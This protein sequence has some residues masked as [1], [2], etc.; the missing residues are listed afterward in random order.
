MKK[1][2]IFT[3]FCMLPSCISGQFTTNTPSVTPEYCNGDGKVTIGIT[4]V[5]LGSTFDYLLQRLSG[6]GIFNDRNGSLG[7]I[8]QTALTVTQSNLP[9]RNSTIRIRENINGNLTTK[10]VSFTIAN[11]YT[12]LQFNN[13]FSYACFGNITVNVTQ[14]IPVTYELK[15]NTNG[16]VVVSAQSSNSFTGLAE[17]N[18]NVALTDQ[19]GNTKV[20][21]ATI[22]DTNT[23]LYFNFSSQD[24]NGFNYLYD[25]SHILHKSDLRRLV[26]TVTVP[27]YKYP[28]NI[29]YEINMQDGSPTG[30]AYI[31][32]YILN[33]SVD[34]GKIVQN[35]P[36]IYGKSFTVKKTLTDTFHNL[37]TI[38]AKSHI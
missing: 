27:N 5:T 13:I 17:G 8:N 33:S 1:I 32:N 36:Y 16:A 23:D 21:G 37:S 19:R 24:L 25:C 29:I 9:A 2:L 15:K 35:I 4:N 10:N 26:S 6:S 14:R 7:V 12:A 18:Y 31:R 28:I 3:L 38:N 34:N 22:T 30:I 20:I 11:N